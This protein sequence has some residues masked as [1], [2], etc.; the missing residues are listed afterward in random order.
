MT[1]SRCSSVCASCVMPNFLVMNLNRIESRIEDRN[2]G[3]VVD[4]NGGRVVDLIE[5]RVVVGCREDSGDV[6]E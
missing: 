2:G 5:D 1:L 4:R 3:R 6:N